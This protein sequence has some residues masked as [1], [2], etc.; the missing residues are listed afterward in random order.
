MRQRAMGWL[1]FLIIGLTVSGCV[2]KVPKNEAASDA[3]SSGMAQAPPSSTSSPE[4]SGSPQSN[5]GRLTPDQADSSGSSNAEAEKWK[6]KASALEAK[7][8]KS[9]GDAKIKK[10]LAEAYYQEGEAIM[11]DN[12][13]PPRMKYKP[14]LLLFDKTL[15][16]N[17]QHQKAAESKATIEAIYRQMGMPI[18]QPDEADQAEA[19]A[20]PPSAPSSAMPGAGETASA[21]SGDAATW[22]K[23]AD[24]LEVQL[25]KNPSDAKIKKELA[26]AYYQEGAAVMFD[27]S[28]APRMKYRPA[29]LLFNKTLSLDPKNQKAAEY[30]TTIEAIYRQMG[31]PIPH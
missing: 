20:P 5:N 13:L 23:K 6:T 29:L 3:S 25:K 21:S 27:D 12:S 14:A 31:M 11:F 16:L 28:L 26:D 17:P 2:E 24:A 7:L 19:S 22:K 1:L 9:P 8:R 10:D 18:P 4:A 30:K 15:K